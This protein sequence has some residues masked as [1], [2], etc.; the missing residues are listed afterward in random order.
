MAVQRDA[1]RDGPPASQPDRNPQG[2]LRVLMVTPRAIPE[3][4]GVERHVA[5]TARRL[6]LLGVDVTVVATDLTGSLPPTETIDGV[7]IVRTPAR[8]A[9]RDYYFSPAMYR[10]IRA[11]K[12]DVVHVQGYHTFVS[13]LT[14]LA[15]KRA[16]LPYVVSFH[17]GPHA[18]LVRRGIRP[19]QHAVLRPLLSGASR[20]VAVSDFERATFVRDLHLP[21]S[22]FGVVRNGCDLPEPGIDVTPVAPVI[23]SIG[24]LERYKGHHRLI[25][26]LPFVR[27]TVP[28]ARALIVGD[29]PYRSELDALARRLGVDD[30]VDFAEVPFGDRLAMARLIS[31]A[32]LVVQ[33]SDYESGGIAALEAAGLGTPVLVREVAALREIVEHGWAS[34]IA[35]DADSYATAE[36]IVDRLQ[37]VQP[38]RPPDGLPTWDGCARHLLE[39]YESVARERRRLRVALITARY[40]PDGGGTAIHTQEVARRLAAR[41]VDVTVLTTTLQPGRASANVEDR[42]PVVQVRAWP[43]G[44]D[45]YLAPGLVRRIWSGRFDLVHCQGYHTLVAPLAML[46]ASLR[47]TPYVLTFHSGGHSSP[48]RRAFRPVQARLLRPLIVR[49]DALI[50]VSAFEADLFAQRLGLPRQAFNV[51]PSGVDLPVPGTILA[52]PGEA[53]PLLLSVGRLVAYKGH[54]RVIE[55]LPYVR[56]SHPG[57]RLRIAGSGPQREALRQLA[58]R[59]GLASSVEIEPIPAESRSEMHSLFKQAAVVAILSEY[60]SQGLAAQEAAA[61]GRPVVVTDSTAMAELRNLDNVTVVS[62]R[63]SAQ[64]VA[65]AI[66]ELIDAPTTTPPPPAPTWEQCADAVL[67]IYRRVLAEV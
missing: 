30:V 3:I 20:L 17:S 46:T 43:R 56:K 58:G 53:D 13:P 21:E 11:T 38:R 16:R 47:R 34:G 48:I 51:I 9:S 6:V 50:A 52:E 54:H 36:A 59:L 49:A 31:S 4:G 7:H 67:D 1:R 32:S 8:P 45:Y 33:L 26:A 10:V 28:D 12:C 2:P 55:A 18:S 61:L 35:A 22:R 14:M 15:A 37:T 62:R 23:A 64:S 60:E 65:A 27:R 39:L 19:V 42:I 57:A 63:A 44:T 24:R 25:A 5:E 41:D 66:I 29:G 40:L